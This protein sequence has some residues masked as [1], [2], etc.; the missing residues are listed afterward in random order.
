VSGREAQATGQDGNEQRDTEYNAVS[1]MSVHADAPLRE[2]ELGM[3][4]RSPSDSTSGT[5]LLHYE[6][7]PCFATGCRAP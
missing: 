7:L 3:R 1:E 6:L 2:R 5:S 4:A